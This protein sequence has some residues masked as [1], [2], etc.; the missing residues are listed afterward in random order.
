MP[1]TAASPAGLFAAAVTF[2]LLVLFSPLV[3]APFWSPRAALLL[4]VAAVGLPTLVRLWWSDARSA[5]MAA[6]GFVAVAALSTAVSPEPLLALIGPYGW[7]TGL[8]FV[9]AVAGAW[10]IGTAVSSS[11]ARLVERAFLAGVLVNAAVAILQ[12]A[13]DLGITELALFDGRAGALVG[14]PVQLGA[15]AVAGFALVAWRLHG[16]PP[17]AAPRWLP[18]ALPAAA[19][20]ELSGSRFALGVAV[21][22]V[23]VAVLRRRIRMAALLA[24]TLVGG[25]AIGTFVAEVGTGEEA[26]SGTERV[27]AD[28]ASG[29]TPRLETWMSAWHAVEDRPVL[30]AGPGRFRAATSRYRTLELVRSQG[31]DSLFVDAH[32]MGVEY[33]VTTGLLGVAALGAWLALA[34][35]GT[36]GPLLG[37][38][39]ALFA[40]HLVQPL[41][42]EVTPLA[43]LTLGAACPRPAPVTGTTRGAIGAALAGA[44]VAGGVLLAGDFR[45]DQAALDFEAPQARAADRLLPAWPEPADVRARI[46][47]FDGVANRRPD[48]LARAARFEHE[49]ARRDPTNPL[50]WNRLGEI[51]LRLEQ[52]LEARERFREALLHDPWSVRALLGYSRASI[53]AG[54]PHGAVHALQRVLVAQPDNGAAREL[55]KT[56]G[57]GG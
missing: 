2:L 45:L 32:N 14:N 52:P 31:P 7:G 49:A 28:P 25:I 41:G 50:W 4:V 53:A 12:T 9:A 55:L 39:L 3:A 43:F 30:G 26:V 6:T 17:A 36:G 33:A 24:A 10:A 48:A 15:V 20:I 18:V 47:A 8:L 19:A 46:H 34:V 21:L 56:A 27:A 16:V 37:A 29:V 54:Q 42:V 38:S 23:A 57:G 1:R 13:V 22:V 40:L 44:L 5:A 11:E 51:E 35:R